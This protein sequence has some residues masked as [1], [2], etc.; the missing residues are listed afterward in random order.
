MEGRGGRGEGR[1]DRRRWC[2]GEGERDKS[3]KKVEGGGAGVKV[4]GVSVMAGGGRGRGS[5]MAGVG[6]AGVMA[7][8]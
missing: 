1:G 8:G 6:G 3:F 4:G 7:G 5:V 2:H